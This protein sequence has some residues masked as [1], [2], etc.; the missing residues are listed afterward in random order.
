MVHADRLQ[1]LMNGGSFY[2]NKFN[3]M[4]KNS[5]TNSLKSKSHKLKLLTQFLRNGMLKIPLVSEFLFLSRLFPA[6]NIFIHKF[7]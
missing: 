6:T 7:S 3:Q 5:N 1:N 4:P 2:T